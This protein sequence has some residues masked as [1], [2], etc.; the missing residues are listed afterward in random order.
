LEPCLP[1]KVATPPAHPSEFYVF[2][3]TKNGGLVMLHTWPLSLEGSKAFV[4]AAVNDLGKN[5]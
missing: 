4:N 2:E 1:G 5:F 3:R